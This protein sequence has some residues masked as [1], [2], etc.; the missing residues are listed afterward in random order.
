MTWKAFD[1]HF[2]LQTN[3]GFE[4]SRCQRA[5]NDG[6]LTLTVTYLF[7]NVSSFDALH[8]PTGGLQVDRQRAAN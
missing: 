5:L 8:G 7:F 3:E 2:P 4:S 6:S 1:F